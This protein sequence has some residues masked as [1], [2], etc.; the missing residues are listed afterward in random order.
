MNVFIANFLGSNYA[1]FFRIYFHIVFFF[2]FNNLFYQHYCITFNVLMTCLIC[3]QSNVLLIFITVAPLPSNSKWAWT[4]RG[5]V[6]RGTK[7]KGHSGCSFH[8]ERSSAEGRASLQCRRTS[9]ARVLGWQKKKK[10]NHDVRTTYDQFCTCFFFFF[11]MNLESR[12]LKI[13]LTLESA[14]ESWGFVHLEFWEKKTFFKRLQILFLKKKFKNPENPV[15]Y[16]FFLL[17][18]NELRITSFKDFLTL[19]SAYES[20]GLVLLQFWKK[21]VFQALANSVLEKKNQKI[22]KIKKNDFFVIWALT[23]LDI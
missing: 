2:E 21:N 3:F 7:L 8:S 17:F 6:N 12:V 19:E 10:R 23:I 13:F 16:L 5:E 4:E 11:W 15:L 1:I 22:L 18:L 20:W 14:Y 9:V